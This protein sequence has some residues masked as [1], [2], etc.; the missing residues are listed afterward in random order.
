MIRDKLITIPL[1]YCRGGKTRVVC[2]VQ[3]AF[4]EDWTVSAPNWCAFDDFVLSSASV[5]LPHCCE[6]ETWELRE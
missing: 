4:S 5:V 1:V 6:S 3:C 2:F